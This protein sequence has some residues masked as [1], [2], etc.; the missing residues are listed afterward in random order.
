MRSGLDIEEYGTGDNVFVTFSE[1]RAFLLLNLLTFSALPISVSGTR[2]SLAEGVVGKRRSR[3]PRDETIGP[4]H[5]HI[6]V[7]L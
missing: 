7:Y 3:R 4:A 1:L 5:D 6:L 2:R